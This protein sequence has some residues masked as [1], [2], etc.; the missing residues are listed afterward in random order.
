MDELSRYVVGRPFPKDSHAVLS[1][2]T[3]VIYYAKQNGINLLDNHLDAAHGENYLE[4]FIRMGK[5]HLAL[6][7]LPYNLTHLGNR[8]NSTFR[9]LLDNLEVSPKYD[10]MYVREHVRQMKKESPEQFLMWRQ[11]N[12]RMVFRLFEQGIMPTDADMLSHATDIVLKQ[13]PDFFNKLKQRQLRRI[14]Q[15]KSPVDICRLIPQQEYT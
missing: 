2:Q 4:F 5:T 12:E 6:A 9:L 11:L 8:T 14:Q 1:E 13:D 7:L 10:Q 3:E 15:A